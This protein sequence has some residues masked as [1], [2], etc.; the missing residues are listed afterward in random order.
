M[1]FRSRYGLDNIPRSIWLPGATEISPLCYRG[2]PLEIVRD[3]AADLG[4]ASAKGADDIGYILQGL[5][6]RGFQVSLPE[7]APR[8]I[9]AAGLVV[10]LLV[11]NIARET[12]QA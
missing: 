1:L 4:F 8:R 2:S 3:L 6:A 9:R 11:S 5:L 7:G 12:P 10:A